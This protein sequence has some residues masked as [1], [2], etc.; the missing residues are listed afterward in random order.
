MGNMHHGNG[1][2]HCECSLS[3]STMK[4]KRQVLQAPVRGAHQ[5]SGAMRWKKRRPSG[6]NAGQPAL[7]ATVRRCRPL[8]ARMTT[9]SEKPV[10]KA[11]TIFLQ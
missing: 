8:D 5:P 3:H 11:R 1:L 6:P 4:H 9:T 7:D 2:H 10:C